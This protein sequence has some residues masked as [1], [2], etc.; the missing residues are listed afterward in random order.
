MCRQR[1]KIFVNRPHATPQTNDMLGFMQRNGTVAQHYAFIGKVP[2]ISVARR[3]AGLSN[4]WRQALGAALIAVLGGLFWL[5]TRYDPVVT[6]L[7]QWPYAIGVLFGL[8]WWLFASPSLLG[9]VIV[10][11]SLWGS[12]RLPMPSRSVGAASSEPPAEATG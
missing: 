4:G 5:G 3:A 7:C 8:A 1:L 2:A 10:A 6:W 11:L 12:L 9:W